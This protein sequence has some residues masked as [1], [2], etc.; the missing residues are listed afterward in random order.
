M[1]LELRPTD[2]PTP[3]LGMD[4]GWQPDVYNKF[5]GNSHYSL[6]AAGTGIHGMPKHLNV[7]PK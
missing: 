7:K 4:F 5:I 6:D 2:L 3:S 1:D